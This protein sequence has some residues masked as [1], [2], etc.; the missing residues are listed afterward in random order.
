MAK[1]KVSSQDIFPLIKQFLYNDQD[2]FLRELVSNAVDATQKLIM[3][4]NKGE[5]SGPIENKCVTVKFDSQRNILIISD[6]GIGMTKEE[7]EKY[8]CQIAFSGATEFIENYKDADIIGHFGMGFYSAFMV[9][10]SVDIYTYSY[11]QNEPGIWWHCDGD[12]NYKIKETPRNEIRTSGT[13]VC[14]HIS[15]SY[16][17]YFTTEHIKSLLEKYNKFIKIPVKFIEMQY[18]YEDAST[19]ETI[20]PDS[21]ETVITSDNALWTKKPQD[22]TDEDYINFYH[23]LYPGKPDPVFWLHLNIDHP[24]TFTGILYFPAYDVKKPLFEKTNLHL[25]CNQVFVTNNL[26]GVLPE[27]LRLLHGIIDSPDI[28]LNMS[29]SDLQSDSN[30]KK[31]RNYISTK[32]MTALKKIMK[33]DR[34][35]YEKKW[36]TIKTFINLGVIME[37]DVY[38]KAQDILLLTDIDGNHYTFDEYYNKVKDTQLDKNGNVIYLYTNDKN[39]HYSA[40]HDLTKMG[41]NILLMDTHYSSF[42]VHS[43]EIE[44]NAKN[45]EENSDKHNVEFKRVDA[46]PVNKLI[47]KESDSEVEELSSELSNMI[48]ALFKSCEP[49][50]PKYSFMFT[51]QH[52]GKDA[53]PIVITVDEFFRR[54]KEM[55]T[56]N[57]SGSYI[58]MD[59][60]LNIVLNEDSDIFK[61]I[62]KNAENAIGKKL[63][64]LNKKAEEINEQYKVADSEKLSDNDVK[65]RNEKFKKLNIEK[66]N[67][68]K[69]YAKT[70]NHINELIDI[71]L[72]EF[73]LLTGESLH[74]F[75]KRSFNMIF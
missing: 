9:A 46:Q 70:D 15:D 39:A 29:R 74:K 40:I 35:E 57:N 21:I 34:A 31:I 23:E 44:I 64:D 52:M 18:P 1:L 41:Y 68:I 73:G 14:L 58:D 5:Y 49:V 65:E 10:D 51:L 75:I 11:K 2:I 55:H 28:P 7:V 53:D 62:L 22:L 54:M 71:A 24:F 17:E 47:E 56:L 59:T 33:N 30:V 3:L 19:G 36:D 12:V 37:K 38:E 72:L 4:F 42:E 43:F 69:E 26:E 67:I 13:D 27:Y 48:I 25:Y 63:T 45:K 61:T 20:T 60:K 16:K 50:I 6:D 66:E 32:V 8:I